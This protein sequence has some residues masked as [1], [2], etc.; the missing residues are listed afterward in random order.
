[1]VQVGYN[2]YSQ[3]YDLKKKKMNEMYPATQGMKKSPVL[4]PN[5]NKWGNSKA[6]AYISN[7]PVGS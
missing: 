2:Y 7:P 1:M 6:S 5:D 3:C 4:D